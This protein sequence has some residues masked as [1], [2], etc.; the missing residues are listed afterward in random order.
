MGC[1]ENEGLYHLQDQVTISALK[2]G[3]TLL[4]W[5]QLSKKNSIKL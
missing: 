4:S 3:L 2:E 5:G 1:I